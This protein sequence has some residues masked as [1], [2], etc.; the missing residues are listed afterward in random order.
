MMPKLIYAQF[1]NVFFH[2]FGD[3]FDLLLIEK[4]NDRL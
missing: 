1:I 3:I 2:Q 4:I